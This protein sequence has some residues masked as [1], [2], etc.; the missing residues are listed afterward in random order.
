[1]RA[2]SGP[3]APSIG[4][5]KAAARLRS[6][7]GHPVTLTWQSVGSRSEPNQ[8]G[9]CLHLPHPVDRSRDGPSRHLHRAHTGRAAGRVARGPGCGDVLLQRA[10]DQ[11]GPR[12]LQ[13]AARRRRPLAGRVLRALVRRHETSRDPNSMSGPDVVGLARWLV[14]PTVRRGAERAVCPEPRATVAAWPN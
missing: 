14:A 13:A 7:T 12:I 8:R 3:R 1:M 2:A 10:G 5:T 4:P 6:G 9:H 11:P